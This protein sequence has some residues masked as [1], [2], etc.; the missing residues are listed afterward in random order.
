MPPDAVIVSASP[1]RVRL[2]VAAR[3][4]DRVYFDGAVARLHRL[5][6]VVG[7]S[8]NPVTGSL[9]IFHHGALD[10]LVD[11]IEAED[12]LSI[13]RERDELPHR[14]N[15]A[16]TMGAA[17]LATAFAGLGLLQLGR[18]HAMPPALTLFWYAGT[19]AAGLVRATAPK[20]PP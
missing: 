19:L 16:A 12:V 1:S 9:L 15:E 20:P 3:R 4:G 11:A 13:D 7:V 17:A 5:A 8:A 2:R 18:R 10:D 6:A 14:L